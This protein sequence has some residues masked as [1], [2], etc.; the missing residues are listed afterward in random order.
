MTVVY[1]AFM[2]Y[3]AYAAVFGTKRVMASGLVVVVVS[4]V[5]LAGVDAIERDRA[6]IEALRAR[7]D[8][9]GAACAGAPAPGLLKGGD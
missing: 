6:N 3:G 8:A 1:F 5:S 2:L 9:V 7:I 4:M